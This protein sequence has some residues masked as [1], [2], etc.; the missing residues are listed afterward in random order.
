MKSMGDSRIG[1]V[2]LDSGEN[3][4]GD[5]V[6]VSLSLVLCLC[7]VCH[8]LGAFF[9]FFRCFGVIVLVLAFLFPRPSYLGRRG[10]RGALLFLSVVFFWLFLT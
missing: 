5:V 6:Y 10:S 2:G 4:A 8:T 3:E 9:S 1:G 7:C